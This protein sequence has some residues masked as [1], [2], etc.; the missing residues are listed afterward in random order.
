MKLPFDFHIHTSYCDGNSSIEQIVCQ[1]VEIGCKAIGF[2]G[3]SFTEFDQSYCMSEQGTEEYINEI[4][5]I[6][7]QYSDKINIFLGLELDLLSKLN[8]SI[9]D[10]VIGSVHYVL[11]DNNYISIDE[12]EETLVS[13]VN[14]FYNGDYYLFAKDYFENVMAVANRHDVDVIGHFDL[15]TKFNEGNRLFDE[16]DKRYLKNATQALEHIVSKKKI[17]EINTGAIYRG[18]RKSPY[19]SVNLLKQLHAMGGSIIISS[20]AHN[21]NA[22]CYLFNQAALIAKESGFNQTKILTDNGF[23]NYQL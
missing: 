4:I 2:T 19:P 6:K 10:F 7:K 8:T 15:I 14:K 21:V 17:V 18:Y 23:E 9:F 13:S 5:K 22:I 11:K 12:S 3:H 1:A 16:N 20:D